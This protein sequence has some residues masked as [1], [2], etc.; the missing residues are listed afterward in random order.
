M[1]VG[2]GVG[3]GVGGSA[4][5]WGSA[6]GSGWAHRG[7]GL[8]PR[9]RSPPRSRPGRCKTGPRGSHPDREGLAQVPRGN[10]GVA[11]AGR[12]GD[13]RSTRQPLVGVG[14]VGGRPRPR[15]R[16]QRLPHGRGRVADGRQHRGG[17]RQRSGCLTAVVW[18]ER[19]TPEVYPDLAAVTSTQVPPAHLPGSHLE[20]LRGGP[21]DHCVVGEPLVDDGEAERLEGD[22]V[23]SLAVRGLPDGRRGVVDG[24]RRRVVDQRGGLALT[25]ASVSADVALPRNVVDLR[26]RHPHRQ[27]LAE[28]ARRH[29]VGLARLRRRCATPFGTPLVGEAR[30]PPRGPGPVPGGQHLAHLG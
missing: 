10:A 6:W 5:A 27:L 2:V 30:R 16:R 18:A 26:C 14:A 4:S 12:A 15:R 20:R 23:P 8:R 22:Q 25:T 29:L 13:R 19:P 3:V 28:L 21:G 11:A 1:G 9:R 24:R 7:S 17:Q